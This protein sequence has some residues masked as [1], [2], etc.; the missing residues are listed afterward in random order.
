MKI[1]GTFHQSTAGLQEHQGTSAGDST[2]ASAG[3]DLEGAKRHPRRPSSE[4]FSEGSGC[5]NRKRQPGRLF[6]IWVTYKPVN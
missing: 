6:S 5:K 3:H 2:V 1:R 4:A